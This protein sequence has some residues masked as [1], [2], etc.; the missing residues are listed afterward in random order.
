MSPNSES[1]DQSR[2]ERIND[3]YWHSDRTIA[4]ITSQMGLSRNALY[5][6]IHPVAARAT[7]AE[8]RE[9]LV[10]TNRTRRDTGLASCRACGAE[11]DLQAAPAAQGALTDGFAPKSAGGRSGR[12][13]TD[14][15][16]TSRGE[17]SWSRW[18]EDLAAVE[19]ERYAL[20]G[21][22]AALG[23]MLGAAAARALRDRG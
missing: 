10:Y 1:P 12:D 20:V 2:D 7:C 22:A 15:W 13:E 3:L 4:E 6:S 17:A 9:R 5:T 19:P 23:V 16:D 14:S 21:G 11:A 8:C 18:R